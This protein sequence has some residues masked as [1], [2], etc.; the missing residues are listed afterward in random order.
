[1]TLAQLL[2]TYLMLDNS[3][4][5]LSKRLKQQ[6]NKKNE[7]ELKV[8]D[9]ITQNNLQDKI[10]TVNDK[11]L[12]LQNQKSNSSFSQKLV[13]EVL[14]EMNIKQEIIEHIFSQI[15]QKRDQNTKENMVLKI[16]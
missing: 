12:F 13:R 7:V 1:M 8:I 16:K 2:K 5:D 14:E 10:I 3:C 4:E 9:T 15:Q 6:R 11:K